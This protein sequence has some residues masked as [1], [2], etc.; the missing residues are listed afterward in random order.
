MKRRGKITLYILFAILM[1][2]LVVVANVVRSNST[3][4][5]VA[6]KIDYRDADTLLLACEL[7]TLVYTKMPQLTR[8][9]IK[10]VDLKAVRQLVDSNPYVADSRVTISVDGTLQVTARQRVAV[11]HLFMDNGD[12]Y[13]DNTG[14]V[15]PS[16]G[17]LI[18]D[19][20]VVNGDIKTIPAGNALQ[21]NL[22]RLADNEKTRRCGLAMAWRLSCF[23]H[24]N[25]R[26]GSLF[27]QIYIEHDNNLV[28]VPKVGSFVVEVG[29]ADNLE[30]KFG[31]LDA[32]VNQGLPLTGWERYSRISIKYVN[33]IVCTKKLI[34]K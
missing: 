15:M 26:Y 34:N 8:Q 6:T 5:G 14:C 23:L 16:R 7:D 31:N 12:L 22:K 10:E 18:A 17:D 1:V 11:M 20:P 24:D 19:V 9:K 13:F 2:A 27:D 3:L 30:R 29:D 21:W 4:K 32:M 25:E 33:Q 28:A